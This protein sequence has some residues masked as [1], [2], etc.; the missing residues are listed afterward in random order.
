MVKWHAQY[1]DGLA[2]LKATTLCGE[3]SLATELS[4]AAMLML[5][6][7]AGERFELVSNLAA[8]AASMLASMDADQDVDGPRSASAQVCAQ[9]LFIFSL[10]S[11]R[12]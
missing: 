11:A 3:D 10:I 9:V 4:G 6:N 1:A 2:A 12:M 5:K 8:S 7:I